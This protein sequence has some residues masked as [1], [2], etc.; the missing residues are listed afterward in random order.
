MNK[1]S[2]D[3]KEDLEMCRPIRVLMIEDSEDDA[4]LIMCELKRNGCEVVSERVDTQRAMI[5]A[6]DRQEWDV[7]VADYS[8]PQFDALKAFKLIQ[9]RNEDLPLI[10]VSGTIGED[11]AVEAM[12]VGVHDYIM[13]DN[14]D[15]LGHAVERALQEAQRRHHIKR[16]EVHL[17]KLSRAV[18]HSPSSIVVTDRSGKIEYVNPKFTRITGYK[19]EEAIGQNPRIMQSGK[20]SVEL[21]KELWD[22]IM[23]GKEWRGELCN[24]KK[25]GELYWESVSISPVNNEDG[26][27]ANYVAVKEDITERKKMEDIIR[28]HNDELEILVE[29]RTAR[30]MELER[31]RVENEKLAVAGRMAAQVAHEINNPLSGIKGGFTLIKD[32][33]PED[34]KYYEYVGMVEGEIDRIARIVKQMFDLCRPYQGGISE[35]DPVVPIRDVVNMLNKISNERCVTINIDGFDNTVKVTMSKDHFKQ[36]LFNII[37]NAIEA[38]LDSSEVN[39]VNIKNQNNRLIIMIS[40][41]G[42]G[43][44]NESRSRIFEPFFTTKD[45]YSDSGLGLGLSTTKGIVE[46]MGG[47]LDFTSEKDKGTTFTIDLPANVVRE[48][49]V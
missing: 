10:L 26:R 20:Q 7:I 6:L 25:N 42:E 5:D 4:A 40:D 17:R 36:I 45:K 11:I 12:K 44:P 15:R 35:F 47:S 22:T 46:A 29:E 28:R 8:I 30:V 2:M 39:I 24:K 23:S 3:N 14:L 48:E 32:A 43:I 1:T 9:E 27:V 13:K 18:E 34:Y 21:Y 41:Q 33:I 49:S 31:Q 16:V 38:S 19:A 37:K